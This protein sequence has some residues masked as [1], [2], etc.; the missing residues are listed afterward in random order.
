[1]LHR[2]V[3]RLQPA[4]DAELAVKARQ[5]IL[6]GLDAEAQTLG[7]RLVVQALL[8]Q[9]QDI[10]LAGGQRGRRRGHVAK[11]DQLVN[12]GARNPPLAGQHPLHG[13]PQVAERLVLQVVAIHAS[14]QQ[15]LDV[16]V[17]VVGADDQDAHVGI[18][19]PDPPDGG[20]R[21]EIRHGHV[22]Q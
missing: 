2:I 10:A 11:A 5:V 8:Q 20:H 15:A 3:D 19:G 17:V 14:S 7:D 1:M 12:Q 9:L 13:Q 18:A 16:D 4:L 6:D 22:D 21:V